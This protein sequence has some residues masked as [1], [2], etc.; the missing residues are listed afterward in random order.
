[1][2]VAYFTN[3]IGFGNRPLKN[4]EFSIS[5]QS[6]TGTRTLSFAPGKHLSVTS[7]CTAP[8]TFWRSV[9]KRHP[10]CWYSIASLEWS[11]QWRHDVRSQDNSSRHIYIYYKRTCYHNHR[12]YR[13]HYSFETYDNDSDYDKNRNMIAIMIV[14]IYIYICICIHWGIGDTLSQLQKNG[15]FVDSVTM[16]YIISP[17][18][19][20]VCLPCQNQSTRVRIFNM[21]MNV[22]EAV[23]TSRV[24]LNLPCLWVLSTY[25]VTISVGLFL[26]NMYGSIQ[27]KE[28][29]LPMI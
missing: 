2:G 17:T 12:L 9:E 19:Q 13:Y 7:V 27:I 10:C 28:M 16:G 18:S 15:P 21:Y 23:G 6:S 29:E 22:G 11:V 4:C 24:S 8:W 5:S 20:V 3:P 25:I 1:M 26:A 14:D